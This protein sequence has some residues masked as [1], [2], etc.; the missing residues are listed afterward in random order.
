MGGSIRLL[1]LGVLVVATLLPASDASA[2]PPT[3]TFSGEDAHVRWSEGAAWE[4]ETAP[5][6]SDGTVDLDFPLSAC[7]RDT[8]GCPTTTDDLSGLTVGKLTLASRVIRSTP[9][10]PFE[11]PPPEPAPESYSIDGSDSLTLLE[12]IDVVNTEEGS[13]EGISAGDTIVDVPLVLGAENVWSIGPAA[14]ARL[15]V[16][17]P[18]SGDHSLTVE[19]AHAQLELAASTNVG[20]ISIAGP[21][22]VFFGEPAGGDLNGGD[23]EPVQVEDVSL[24]GSG[25]IGPLSLRD[26]SMRIGFPGGGGVVHVNGDATFDAASV[27]S[28]ENPQPPGSLPRLLA[29]GSVQLGSAMLFLY[30]NCPP[31]GTTLTLVEAGGGVSGTFTDRA[32]EPLSNGETIAAEEAGC[33]PG[34]SAH[35][36]KI[37]YNADSVTVTALSPPAASTGG[38]QSGESTSSPQQPSSSGGSGSGASNPEGG[39]AAYIASLRS[40]LARDLAVAELTRSIR[41]LLRH[42]GE[43]VALDAPGAGALTVTLTTAGHGTHARAEVLG[44]GHARLAASGEKVRLRIELTRRGTAL[45]AHTTHLPVELT[46]T[47]TAPGV[48]SLALSAKLTLTR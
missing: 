47:F 17:A 3:F 11:T 24:Y 27:V 9:K 42:G 40:L 16:W 2:A 48:S 36:L 35:P 46:E 43:T 12:G 32:G 21:G 28:F 5:S 37:E 45:L 34:P 6:E 22:S 13:G 10:H 14:G 31:P 8:L 33:P 23:G 15:T 4:G 39:V 19:L 44:S 38:G 29:S 30:A 7:G 41:K 18:V 1:A 25:V 20:P 26:S